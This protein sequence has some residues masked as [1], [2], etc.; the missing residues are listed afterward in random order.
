MGRALPRIAVVVVAVTL[1]AALG[2]F[3]AVRLLG[4]RTPAPGAATGTEVT[5]TASSGTATPA[6]ETTPPPEPTA[7]VEPTRTPEA[8]RFDASR[9]M[10]HV[11]AVTALGVR[12]GGSGAESR[13]AAYVVDQ[14]RAM[15]Y[16]PK[17]ETFK[18]TNGARSRNVVVRIPGEVEDVFVIGAHID[19]KPPSP[20]GNDNASGVGMLLELARVWSDGRGPRLTLELVFFGSE[21]II[22]GVSSHHHFGSRYRVSRMPEAERGRT[23]GMI[24]LDMV[25]Y[26]RTIN[27]RTMLRGPRSLSDMLIREGRRAGLTISFLKDG[28]RTGWSDHEPYENAG[29]PA[30]WLGRQQDPVYHSAKDTASHVQP[31][32]L[33]Q[34]GEFVQTFVEGLDGEAVAELRGD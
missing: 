21:E 8:E 23:A 13:A 30:A 33:G 26:G 16:E 34:V 3:G 27:T 32:R 17:V 22:D 20:G 5:G 24:S 29:I 18:L 7:T 1:A 15:G 11:R 19:S 4:P 28:G 6:V 2:W 9:A 12:K 31:D 10:T 14:L 25:G